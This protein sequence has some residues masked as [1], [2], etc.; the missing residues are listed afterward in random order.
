SAS[1]PAGAAGGADGP[2]PAPPCF[3]GGARPP[4]VRGG[5]RSRRRAWQRG[6]GLDSAVVCRRA[7]LAPVTAALGRSPGGPAAPAAGRA[8]PGV[9]TTTS[10]AGAARLEAV[11]FRATAAGGAAVAAGPGHRLRPESRGT[12]APLSA[13][14][15]S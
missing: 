9:A 2:G 5:R 1:P 14:K 12:L 11:A 13:Q 4:Q 15:I 3:W 7:R 8:T 6:P 10:G